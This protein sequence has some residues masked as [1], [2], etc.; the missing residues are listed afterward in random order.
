MNLFLRA[1]HWQ[2]FLL[3]FGLPFVFQIVM[4][5]NIFSNLMVNHNPGMILDYFKFFPIMMLLCVGTLFGWLWSVGMRLQKMVPA[6][7]NMKTTRFKIFFFIPVVYILLLMGFLTFVFSSGVIFSGGQPNP[8]IFYLFPIIFPLHL[9]SMFC[10]FYCIFFVAKTI[11]TVELQRTV[12]FSDFMAEFFLVWFNLIGIW[13]LQPKINKM[14]DG[15]K[16]DLIE[17]TD[18]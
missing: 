12:V 11:K 18:N 3:T 2:I 1:K 9:F 14:A 17:N 8:E 4:M 15:N 5:V 16:S 13:I 10:I 6:T 7:V